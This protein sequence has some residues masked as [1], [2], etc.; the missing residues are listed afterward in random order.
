MDDQQPFDA[1]LLFSFGGP[2]G[3]D[4]VMPFLENVTRGKNIPRARLEAVAE[5]YMLFDGV[6]PIN[7]HLRALLVAVIGELNERGPAIPVFWANRFW[8]PLLPEVLAEMAE[9]G[10]GRALAFVT[11]A[12]GSYPG[13]RAYRE[14]IDEARASLGSGAPQ[15]DKIRLFYDHPDFIAAQADRVRRAAEAFGND[16]QRVLF[17]AHSIPQAMA[18]VSPYE[19]QLHEACRWTAEQAGLSD[20]RLA[21]QSRSG[22]PNEPWLEPSV[23]DTLAQWAAEGCRRVVLAPIGFLVE[24]MEVAYDLDIEAAG[25]CRRLGI[26][27]VRAGTVGGHPR[28]TTMIRKLIAERFDPRVPRESLRPEGPG[29]D[30]CPPDCC[31]TNVANTAR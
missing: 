6:S 8:R 16:R 24:H 4:E 29:D 12:F 2:E 10:V 27:M 1:L 17:T 21:Y 28:L 9:Q 31:R 11:S 7:E 30:L 20:W 5:H 14:A 23:E 15:V 25:H 26:E 18:A 19:R 13:C 22:P 3:P